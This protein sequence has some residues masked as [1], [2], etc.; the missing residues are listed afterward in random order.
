MACRLSARTVLRLVSR[1]S[2]RLVGA[3]WRTQVT[4]QPEP[5]LPSPSSLAA[6]TPAYPIAS[7]FTGTQYLGTYAS[8]EEAALV[9]AR[10]RAGAVAACNDDDDTVDEA[11]E[12]LDSR[13]AVT[14][15]TA[16]GLELEVGHSSTGYMGVYEQGDSFAARPS[17]G[18]AHTPE[19]PTCQYSHF[20]TC[21]FCSRCDT[22]CRHLLIGG[23]GGTGCRAGEGGGRSNGGG[24][25]GGWRRAGGFL[26]R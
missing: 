9:Y 2:T 5:P 12:E 4:A 22:I 3:L 19:Q 24:D 17:I 25:F 14:A 23:N 15:A 26:A 7:P 13:A 10:A 16:E 11:E 21:G 6:F 8:P 18:G 20:L 1:A